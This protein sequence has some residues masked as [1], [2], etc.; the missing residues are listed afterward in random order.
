MSAAEAGDEIEAVLLCIG[1]KAGV[2]HSF[3]S[4]TP[5]VYRCVSSA[6][7]QPALQ[8]SRRG[9][10]VVASSMTALMFACRAYD[11]YATTKTVEVFGN[12][13]LIF[14]FKLRLLDFARA[15]SAQCPVESLAAPAG[16][17][18]AITASTSFR[19]GESVRFLKVRAP[20]NSRLHA[21][22]ACTGNVCG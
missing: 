20:A 4:S 18:H 16:A 6:I 10:L 13:V 22:A 19:R 14:A 12:G 7:W 1:H 3:F 2:A 11:M 21:R 17:A 9:L 8:P 15:A 5:N